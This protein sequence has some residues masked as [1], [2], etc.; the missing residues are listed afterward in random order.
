MT[1]TVHEADLQTGILRPW[2]IVVWDDPV[3]LMSY[4]T[5]VF[6]QVFAYPKEV[7]ERLMLQV[8]ND[9]K[10]IVASGP[11]ESMEVK[12]ALLHEFGLWATIELDQ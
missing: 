8:H 6:M 3:N 11:R 10:S 9:G 2:K 4:V 1:S 7:A 5:H 12:T